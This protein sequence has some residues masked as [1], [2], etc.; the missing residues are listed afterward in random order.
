MVCG[1][2]TPATSGTGHIDLVE[3]IVCGN[4]NCGAFPEWD[5]TE[6]TEGKR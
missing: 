3:R 1:L 2:D 6:K 4:R 5:K